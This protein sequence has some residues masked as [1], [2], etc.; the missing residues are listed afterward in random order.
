MLRF[1]FLLALG[2]TTIALT[3]CNEK[4]ESVHVNGLSFENEFDAQAA[5]N[6]IEISCENPTGCPS[7]VGGL[8]AER[9]TYKAKKAGGYEKSF[10][11]SVCSQTLIAPNRVLTNRHCLTP[12]VRVAGSSC[13]EVTLIFP[14]IPGRDGERVKCKSILSLSAQ[15]GKGDRFAP[16]W[17]ILEL[18]SNVDRTPVEVNPQG[19]ANLSDLK[20]FP[21]YY[22]KI[23]SGQQGVSTLKGAIESVSCVSRMNTLLSRHYNHPL[24][25]LVALNCDHEIIRGNSGTGM[26]GA[27]GKLHGVLSAAILH[28]PDEKGPR[29]DKLLGQTLVLKRDLG[30]G[31]NAFCIEALSSLASNDTCK[32]KLNDEP[33]LQAGLEF[34]IAAGLSVAP[35]EKNL[36]EEI[37]QSDQGVVW[38]DHN[39]EFMSKILKNDNYGSLVSLF[40]PPVIDYVQGQEAKARY[41][42]T[43]KCIASER[44]WGPEFQIEMPRYNARG[45]DVTLS[46]RS[47][48][49]VPM[50]VETLVFNV[51]FS[52]EDNAFSAN[53]ARLEE[54]LRTEY[55]GLLEKSEELF[56]DPCFYGGEKK[57]CEPLAQATEVVDRYILA[58]GLNPSL[59]VNEDFIR[60]NQRGSEIIS[61]PVCE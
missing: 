9:T 42:K 43:P 31:T 25:P 28:N 23:D 26:L 18:E 30:G 29:Q 58:S 56:F 15:Y 41:P 40:S 4:D 21:V 52:T 10:G 24:S 12:T 5:L 37:I 6:K 48:F 39:A 16:D 20:L 13:S 8:V 59:F 36:F 19:I 7:Y 50:R 27:D 51:R 22:Q 47:I 38:E 54:N 61:I 33:A 32:F 49:N 3:N 55:V 14:P 46:D 11:F 2:L 45:K 60:S 57:D 35:K 34:S 44:S 53:L 17:A 1:V